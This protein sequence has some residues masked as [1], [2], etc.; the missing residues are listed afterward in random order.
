M[1]YTI[2][3]KTMKIKEQEPNS[4]NEN[5]TRGPGKVRILEPIYFRFQSAVKEIK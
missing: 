2:Q 3:N 4:R 1:T 5:E